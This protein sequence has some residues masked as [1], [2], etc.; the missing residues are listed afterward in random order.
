LRSAPIAS[1]A[2]IATDIPDR[3]WVVPNLRTISHAHNVAIGDAAH[4]VAPTGAPYR[5]SAFVAITSGAYAADLILAQETKLQLDPFSF[6]TLGKGISIGRRGVGFP[7]YPDD[8]QRWFILT[9]NTARIVRNLFVRFIGFALELKRRLPGFFVWPGR[10]R[11][12]WNQANQAMR[13]VRTKQK[14]Q[15]V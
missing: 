10:R 1:D 13:Q 8:R 5:L 12:S 14:V 9:G 15:T 7:S 4:L 11:V 2:G 3:L 6:S